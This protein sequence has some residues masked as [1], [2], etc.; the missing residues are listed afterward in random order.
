MQN[1]SHQNNITIVSKAGCSNWCCSLH[2]TVNQS[3]LTQE[4]DEG[5]KGLK[6]ELDERDLLSTG[7]DC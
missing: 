1:I 6:K 4:P 2:V 5:T 7:T 3:Q